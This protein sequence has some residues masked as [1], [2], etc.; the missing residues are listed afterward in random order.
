MKRKIFTSMFIAVFGL[1][2]TGCGSP[3]ANEKADTNDKIQIMT[4]FYPMYEFTKEVAGD[5]ADVE[6]MIPAGTEPHD[7]EP[8][9][10]AVAKLTEAD[11][12][13]YN[14][15][16][17]ETWVED[18]STNIDKKQT[19]I[20]EASSGIKLMEGAEE[21]ET[22]GHDHDHTL[23]PHVWL[24]PVLASQEV[25]NIKNALSEKFPEQKATF[26][27]NAAAYQDKLAELDKEFAEAFAGANKRDFVT[28]HAAF[29]YLAHQ[30]D[31]N[32]IAISG[33]SP[34]EEPSASR[35]AEL[36][37][38]VSKNDISYIYFEENTNSKVAETLAKEAN[39]KTLVLNPL[40]SLSEK[41]IKAGESYLTVMK[42]NLTALKKTIQ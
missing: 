13:V 1:L 19:K 35:L 20:V 29:G 11:V 33:L 32:Q 22:E 38:Y 6:L 23:D 41:Q 12:F 9:A 2:L 4:T 17:L 21:E 31:L 14:S 16:E 8:S 24:S 39:V 18:I 40:E 25:E 37:E 34:E 3:A 36:K 27:K 7:Y 5:T 30:Y 15:K 26:E 28:Q 42:E 10:R